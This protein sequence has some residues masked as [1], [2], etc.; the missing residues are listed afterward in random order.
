[1]L[2]KVQVVKKVQKVKKV[3]RNSPAL[4]ENNPALQYVFGGQTAPS[5]AHCERSAQIICIGLPNPAYSNRL[6][7]ISLT[8]TGFAKSALFKPGLQNPAL[9]N[10]GLLNS[11]SSKSGFPNPAWEI[12]LKKNRV[13]LIPLGKSSLRKIGFS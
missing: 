5:P 2:Q 4:R 1:M 3:N 8:Q 11:P 12:Q 10:P 7:K 13:F 6:C 9:R